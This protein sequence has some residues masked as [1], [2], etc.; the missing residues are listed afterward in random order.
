MFFKLNNIAIYQHSKNIYVLAHIFG[1][2]N[3]SG[4][5]LYM[6]YA[7]ISWRCWFKPDTISYGF[8]SNNFWNIIFCY[9]VYNARV[10]PSWKFRAS[11]ASSFSFISIW[12]TPSYCHDVD[13]NQKQLITVSIAT[14]F[15]K[16]YFAARFIMVVCFHPENFVLIVTLVLEL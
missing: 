11:H 1:N 12:N 9:W 3:V 8:H 7:L 5:L 15:L 13:L 10:F 4:K 2:L 16:R 6:K 14:T